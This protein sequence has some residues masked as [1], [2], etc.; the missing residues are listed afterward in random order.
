MTDNSGRVRPQSVVSGLKDEQQ[1]SRQVLI[2][3]PQHEYLKSKLAELTEL[4]L[5]PPQASVYVTLLSLGAAG[6]RTISSA[7]GLARE[8]TYR[9]LR[10]LGSLGLVEIIMERP[11]AFSAVEPELGVKVLLS[12]L[13]NRFD[14]IQKNAM[15][16]TE[17]LKGIDR[18]EKTY[19]A[20]PNKY[21]FKL[22][23]GSQIF[24]RMERL[25]KSCKT[26][27]V[28]VTS[29]TGICQNY[30]LG[31]IDLEEEV[32]KRG[33]KVRAVTEVD[34]NNRGI[35]EEY[36]KFADVRHLPAVRSML[37][38][39]VADSDQMIFFTTNPA[40]DVRDLGAIWT[41]S[42]PLIEGFQTEFE[43]SWSAAMPLSDR[44]RT[45]RLQ[46]SVS[47]R[48]PHHSGI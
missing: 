29:G 34:S 24:D 6:A 39:V 43:Q 26:S 13:Q 28:R 19:Q 33:G 15:A 16:I 32:A 46:K 12:R 4:G 31:I 35:V 45:P 30:V 1:R 22:E 42:R 18:V 7:S 37:K 40:Q 48:E 11:Y 21:L 5:T 20:Q 44:G 2:T 36:A 3:G 8:D 10:A 47:G 14:G 9:A 27:L 23:G 41:N 25:I 17:W 38:F